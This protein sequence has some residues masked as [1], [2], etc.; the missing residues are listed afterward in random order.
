MASLLLWMAALSAL[1]TLLPSG[2][3]LSSG[4]ARLAIDLARYDTQAWDQ[5]RVRRAKRDA[6]TQQCRRCTHALALDFD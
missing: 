2:L 4:L 6:A 5:T 3:A 1:A